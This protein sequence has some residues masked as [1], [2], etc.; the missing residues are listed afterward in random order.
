MV[1][2]PADT[3]I[4]NS[5]KF[6]Y[7]ANVGWISLSNLFAF[8]QTDT[9]DPGPDSDL[10]GILDP[11]ELDERGN[12]TDLSA[13]SDFDGDGVNDDGEYASDTDPNDANENLRI[14]VQNLNSGGT[15]SVV[16]W[17][18]EPSRKYFVETLESPT[19]GW[20]DSGLGQQDPDG[21]TTTRNIPHT[22]GTNRFFRAR[23]VVPLSP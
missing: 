23:A 6:A 11:W 14:T 10:D 9:I 20:A 18:T 12:L 19:D 15:T 2:S 4:N 3:T 5:N 16:T 22:S 13:G 8:V 17:T 7:G 21:A 1:S